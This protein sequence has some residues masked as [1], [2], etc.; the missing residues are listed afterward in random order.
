MGVGGTKEIFKLYMKM[1]KPILT[2]MTVA[3]FANYIIGMFVTYRELVDFHAIMT[4]V[5]KKIEI[6]DAR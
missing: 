5:D 6:I 1:T 2:P 4:K 3:F